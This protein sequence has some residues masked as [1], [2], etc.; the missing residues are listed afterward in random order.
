MRL[1]GGS[2]GT[3]GGKLLSETPVGGVVGNPAAVVVAA[4]AGVLVVGFA[5]FLDFGGILKVKEGEGG[6]NE[7]GAERGAEGGGVELEPGEVE[8][9]LD[10]WVGRAETMVGML[11][12]L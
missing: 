10:P 12:G 9:R 11:H 3:R 4:G 5:G 1:D 7:G 2:S 6:G 8:I